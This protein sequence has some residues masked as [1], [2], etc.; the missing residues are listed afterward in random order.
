MLN[1]IL[2][3][4]LY[5]KKDEKTKIPLYFQNKMVTI[6]SF[7]VSPLY[8]MIIYLASFFFS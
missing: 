6:V 4:H 8:L 2:I 1:T 5:F 3:M 7:A